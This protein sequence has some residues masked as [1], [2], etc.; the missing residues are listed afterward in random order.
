MIGVMTW[1]GKGWKRDVI[2]KERYLG[3]GCLDY[4][5]VH[6]EGENGR[7]ITR[8]LVVLILRR[9]VIATQHI[10]VKLNRKVAT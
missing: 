9:V 2:G 8:E 10:P 4:D 6:G 5:A 7:G 1:L 3:H